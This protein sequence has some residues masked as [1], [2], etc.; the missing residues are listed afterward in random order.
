MTSSWMIWALRCSKDETLGLVRPKSPW[1][2]SLMYVPADACRAAS[3]RCK[4]RRAFAVRE[5]CPRRRVQVLA[6]K[7]RCS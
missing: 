7:I 3:G 5:I 2:N 1:T 6:M 4:R